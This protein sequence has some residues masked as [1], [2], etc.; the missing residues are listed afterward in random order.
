MKAQAGINI[1]VRTGDVF[2]PDY[3]MRFVLWTVLE[4]DHSAE[5][6]GFP[7]APEPTHIFV[8]RSRSHGSHGVTFSDGEVRVYLPVKY[9]PHDGGDGRFLDS[10]SFSLYDWAEALVAVTAH[11]CAHLR[12]VPGN[13][14]IRE[15]R[16]GTVSGDRT[17]EQLCQLVALKTLEKFRMVRAVLETM[18]TKINTIT[19]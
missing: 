12:G 17:G 7:R 10:I 5:L 18:M 16:R 14:K 4:V 6:L 2:P 9:Y 8:R 19:K 3:V 15:R 11:E 1:H 13:V